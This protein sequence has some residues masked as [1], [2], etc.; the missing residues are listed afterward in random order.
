MLSKMNVSVDPCN[1]FYHYA[2]ESFITDVTIPPSH[3]IHS[4]LGI[5]KNRKVARVRKVSVNFYT[6]SHLLSVRM[7]LLLYFPFL[8]S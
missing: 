1:D 6:T 8:F 3:P 5:V 2:C 7:L 4:T